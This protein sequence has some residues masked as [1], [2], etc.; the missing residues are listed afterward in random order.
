MPSNREQ[1]HLMILR[2]FLAAVDQHGDERL[3][4]PELAK[5]VG[6]SHRVLFTICSDYLGVSPQQFIIAHRLRLA[7]AALLAG[8][9]VTVAAANSG[10]YQPGRFARYYRRMFGEM[11]LDTKQRVHPPSGKRRHRRRRIASASKPT[12]EA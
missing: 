10:F 2:R 1:R 7:R 11:P 12:S 3:S 6:A 9:S 8:A 5:S 4:L